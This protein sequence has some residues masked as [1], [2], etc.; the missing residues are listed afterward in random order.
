MLERL[1]PK[2]I[3]ELELQVE[4]FVKPRLLLVLRMIPIICSY[5]PPIERRK[6]EPKSSIAEDEVF[7]FERRDSRIMNGKDQ[8]LQVPK[9]DSKFIREDGYEVDNTFDHSKFVFVHEEL[10]DSVIDEPEL[11]PE[12]VYEDDTV[13]MKKP[14]K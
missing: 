4:H 14:E 7:F 11:S 5:V 1:V 3:T 8:F 9:D 2:L 12:T 10:P 6:E 13:F